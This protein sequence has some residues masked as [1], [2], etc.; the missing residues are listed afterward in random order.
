MGPRSLIRDALDVCWV[1]IKLALRILSMLDL[2]V[3]GVFAQSIERKKVLLV[4]CHLLADDN[5]LCAARRNGA[6]GA[7]KPS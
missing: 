5:R 4:V 3:Q 7:P 2:L 1:W 6:L